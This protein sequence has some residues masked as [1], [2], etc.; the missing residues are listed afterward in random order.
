MPDLVLYSPSATHRT[1]S[2]RWPSTLDCGIHILSHSHRMLLAGPTKV[3]KVNN[4]TRLWDARSCLITH[5][6]L[7][8]G[9]IK[10]IKMNN[11]CLI[12]TE[13]YSP[14]IPR[15]QSDQTHWIMRCWS[16]LLL[17]ECYSLDLPR[18]SRWTKKSTLWDVRYCVI[19]SECYS[20]DLPCLQG[21]QPNWIV[22]CRSCFITHWTLLVGLTKVIKVNNYCLILTECYK[23][24]TIQ[25]WDAWSY[26]IL[27]ECYSWYL[28]MSSKWTKQ[29]GL[30]DTD[31]FS[32]SPSA[33]CRTYQCH[34]GE[35]L[36]C[37]NHRVLLAGLTNVIKVNK[38]YWIVRCLYLILTECYSPDLPRSSRWTN[39]FSYSTS[40]THQA[41]QGHQGD[42]TYL[43]VRCRS[44]L[45]LTKS[46]LPD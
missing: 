25:M 46:Y 6:V 34:Q 31:I 18:S 15:Y 2:S 32:F 12:L 10:V 20:P 29:T 7:L 27:L 39:L 28:P 41:Y 3:I 19:L 26:L 21:G 4:E 17:I 42:Q 30:W 35:Q 43:I 9:L 5:R 40:A 44:C 22:R 14:D 37:H 1:R 24:T 11:L 33:T 16:C 8:V 36:L 23:R 38:P 45:I 13:Y